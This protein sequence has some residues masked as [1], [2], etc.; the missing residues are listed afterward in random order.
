MIS[1][2]F[3]FSFS[4]W[5]RALDKLTL[6]L[7]LVLLAI[8]F[9]LSFSASPA[10]A[11]KLGLDSYYFIFRHGLFLF[12]SLLLLLLPSFFD[13]RF[14]RRLSGLLLL[15]S[16]LFLVSLPFI[17]F[18]AKGSTRWLSLGFFLIQPSEFLKP[19]FIIIVAWLFSQRDRQPDIPCSL[20]SIFLLLF[21]IFLLLLQ[22]DMGQ[23]VLL[24]L[25]WSGL[26][27]MAGMS[28]SWVLGLFILGLLGSFLA[29]INFSHV[30][31]RIDRF[32]TGSGDNY[33][34]DQGLNAIM[35]G[36]WFGTGPGEGD[37]KHSLPDSHTDFVFS[38]AVEEFGIL[39]SIILILV[40]G[41]IVFRSLFHALCEQDM[42]I[43]FSV[44]GLSLLLGFQVLINLGVNLSLL[45]TKGMTLPFISYGGSSLLSMSL[46]MGILL[47]F[48]RKRADHYRRGSL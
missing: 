21:S 37:I 44:S 2:S 19:C 5:W 17:G 20:F 27:F 41:F 8:G 9:L 4:E 35:N 46:A 47:A 24:T 30:A 10:V 45:P 23:A 22:P 28:W 40:F 3:K 16:L 33:Q 15:L 32:F 38:V 14:L 48:T 1:I 11:K 43:Q 26:F 18:T 13:V 36:G 42:F 31:G 29:Y 39:F 34:V 6:S 7:L 25:V 12:P